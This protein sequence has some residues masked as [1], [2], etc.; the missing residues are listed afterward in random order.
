M[1]AIRAAS[2]SLK[3]FKTFIPAVDLLASAIVCC[4][5]MS[6]IV[7]TPTLPN[8]VISDSNASAFLVFSPLYFVGLKASSVLL[9]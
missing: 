2:S 1:Y 8:T 5:R 6:S 3:T 4:A 9:T 7:D